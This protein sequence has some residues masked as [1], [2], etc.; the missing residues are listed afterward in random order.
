[1]LTSTGLS[2][3]SPLPGWP[4]SPR[5]QHFTVSTSDTTQ[6]CCPE[7]EGLLK[8]RRVV[9]LLAVGDC[10]QLAH[11]ANHVDGAHHDHQIQ[12]T[13]GLIHDLE[14]PAN[15]RIE[16]V[17]LERRGRNLVDG[18][19][20]QQLGMAAERLAVARQRG[21]TVGANAARVGRAANQ[22]GAAS[23]RRTT[24]REN[25]TQTRSASSREEISWPRDRPHLRA[26]A[27]A[28]PGRLALRRL[29]LEIRR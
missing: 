29:V 15:T 14:Q 10:Q 12:E 28:R 8:L 20:D 6:V 26:V 27:L 23:F 2:L 24:E 7:V 3:S 4:V 13:L 16:D 5:P 25:V 11:H 9:L 17:A 21:A 19:G 1:M 18:Q 22:D